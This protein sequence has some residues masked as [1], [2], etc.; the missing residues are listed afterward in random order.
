MAAIIAKSKEFSKIYEKFC[1]NIKMNLS[2][3]QYLTLPLVNIHKLRDDTLFNILQGIDLALNNLYQMD[4]IWNENRYNPLLTASMK[5]LFEFLQT[6]ILIPHKPTIF[7][8][9]ETKDNIKNENIYEWIPR[10][11]KTNLISLVYV[12]L[13][14]FF[15]LV[16]LKTQN[17]TFFVIL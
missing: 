11:N 5:P 17:Y 16:V 14:F 9:D 2:F 6:I 15:F 12:I 10:T 13:F 1:S 4:P 3:M 7:P 8:L